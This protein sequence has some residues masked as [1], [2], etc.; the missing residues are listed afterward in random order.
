M[1]DLTTFTV[2][3]LTKS[4]SDIEYLISYWNQLV[5]NLPFDEFVTINLY[6]HCY[7]DDIL[8]RSIQAM[9]FHCDFTKSVHIIWPISC[10]HTVCSI[11]YRRKYGIQHLKYDMLHMLSLIAYQ[12][13]V[14][15]LNKAVESRLSELVR[16]A[17][18]ASWPFYPLLG[19]VQVSITEAVEIAT[20]YNCAQLINA[21]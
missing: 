5:S 10:L 19:I 11:P 20:G 15:T 21:S 17:R 7:D 2:G 6:N 4:G 18:L 12:V 9:G 16:Y 3:L 14:K 1:D 13:K 8:G